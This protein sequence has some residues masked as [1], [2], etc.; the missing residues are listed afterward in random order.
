[1]KKTISLILL[2]AGIFI[3]TCSAHAA[4]MQFSDISIDLET[5]VTHNLVLPDTWEGTGVTWTTDGVYIE[6]DGTVNR[7]YPDDAQ[8]V[9][10]TAEYGGTTK[11]FTVTVKAFES[12]K[13]IVRTAAMYLSFSDISTDDSNY[14]ETDLYLPGE[15]L[16]GTDILWS[17]GNPSLID[18]VSDGNG[19]YIG[20]VSRTHLGEGNYG[21][22][23][24][25]VF[26]FE[27]EFFEKHFYINIAEDSMDYTLPEDLTKL[28]DTYRDEFL[29]R[30][31]IFD[32]RSDLILPQITT[33]IEMTCVS[34][35]P[36]VVTADGVVTRDKFYDK[37][38]TFTVNFK[39]GY[40]TTNL[41][42]PIV[43]TAYSNSELEKI[44]EDDVKNLIAEITRNNSMNALMNNLTLKTTGPNGSAVTW[45]SSD[46]SAM[47]NTGVITRGTNDK[48]VT[49]TVT[50]DFKGHTYTESID[51][52]IKRNSTTSVTET[53]P[54]ISGSPGF[55]APS[56]PVTP[57]SGEII[58]FDDL[59]SDHW[60]Y[61]NIMGLVENN[62]VGGYD[63][64]TFRPGNAVT[65]EE[66]V[67]MLLLA[68]DNYSAG[69][70]SEFSDVAEDSWYYTYVS[71]AYKKGIVQGIANDLFG[72]GISIS[73][74]DAAV[75][76]C[77]ALGI[78]TETVNETVFP[79]FDN[80]SGYAQNAVCTLYES[81]VINGDD[82]G[83][84]NPKNN[85]TRAE[86]S[87]IL[88]LVM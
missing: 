53:T 50:A 73:R 55:S 87:K 70:D 41:I 39:K 67:K 38:V 36:D 28:R 15:G 60:A 43:V 84:F 14:V 11:T 40:I 10:I 47:T 85:I 20:K 52:I 72:S 4:E 30:N 23:L 80:I 8:N 68:T 74:Q 77:R 83:Y 69:Y 34:G 29:K 6:S 58:Y 24:T 42:I 2:L 88:S 35:N 1:M 71:C 76:I 44:P 82:N 54:V 51:I 48:T 64:N 65:R 66:F 27:N 49:L 9:T 12:K 75:M 3:G 5:A 78:E 26:Y 86:V 16:Y 63:D 7:P 19:N 62:V 18:V 32:L 31:N 79:D 25:A 46:I 61:D 56:A 81:G 59:S 37:K 13:E 22:R 33:D 57:P 17:R 21:V 45:S